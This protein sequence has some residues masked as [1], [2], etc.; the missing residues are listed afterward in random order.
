MMTSFPCL[1]HT[2]QINW[3]IFAILVL[4]SFPIIEGSAQSAIS[5]LQNG[6]RTTADVKKRVLGELMDSLQTALNLTPLE[7]APVVQNGTRSIQRFDQAA[8]LASFAEMRD[9]LGLDFDMPT[10]INANSIG[11]LLT[12][13]LEAAKEQ[14]P[15]V[16]TS[17]VTQVAQLVA[18]LNGS[19]TKDGRKPLMSW[20]FKMGLDSSLADSILVPFG[21]YQGFLD[22]SMRIQVF[23]IW[24]KPASPATRNTTTALGART[25]REWGLVIR[26]HSE[27]CQILH[28][29]LHLTLLKSS[30]IQRFSSCPFLTQEDKGRILSVFSTIR[31]ISL[32]RKPCWTAFLQT[33]CLE[34]LTRFR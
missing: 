30:R 20:G 8:F 23:S 34:H 15:S 16:Q 18:T 17:I 24:T 6:N 22:T 9:E 14:P 10:R 19:V 11:N 13:V 29:D 33:V 28:P 21:D 2:R 26:C 1:G 3:R 4:L 7:V 5:I 12:M 31:W 32:Q 25:K 27:H